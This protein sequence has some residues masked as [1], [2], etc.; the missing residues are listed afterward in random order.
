MAIKSFRSPLGRARGTGSTGQGTDHWWHQRLTSLAL[1]P[2]ALYL[3]GTFLAYVVWGRSYASARAWLHS[4][5]TAAA[6][7]LLIGVGFHHGAAGLQVIIED[8]LHCEKLKIVA[9]I[10][11]KFAAGFLALIGILAVLKILLGA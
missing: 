5:V 3:I 1:I 2:L 4:P 6:V 9:L 11:V 8:D 10:A 7:I